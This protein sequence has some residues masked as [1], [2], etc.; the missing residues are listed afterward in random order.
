MSSEQGSQPGPRKEYGDAAS[1]QRHPPHVD[2]GSTSDTPVLPANAHGA[3]RQPNEQHQD[4]EI[5]PESMYDRR[6]G[7]D[8]DRG[9]R[10]MP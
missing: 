7:E 2:E 4:R 9:K 5:D 1:S 3:D 8:K 10:E 6:P